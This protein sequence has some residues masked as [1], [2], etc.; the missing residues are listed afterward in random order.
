M[1]TYY[2]LETHWVTASRSS[3]THV[4]KCNVSN[5][6]GAGKPATG[7]RVG[8]GLGREAETQSN[9]GLNDAE[10]TSLSCEPGGRQSGLAWGPVSRQAHPVC[11]TLFC[12]GGLHSRGRLVVP[13]VRSPQREGRAL[14][15]FEGVSVHLDHS[16]PGVGA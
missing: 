11:S 10:A 6:V 14:L 2:V 8:T 5:V 9:S 16:P 1:H 15:C 4:N 13:G 12:T 3:D 7:A